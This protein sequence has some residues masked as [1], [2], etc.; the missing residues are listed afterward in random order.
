[1][2]AKALGDKRKEIIISSKVWVDHMQKKDIIE[3][4]DRSL[5][6]L[7]T[8]YLDMYLLHWPVAEVPIEERIEALRELKAAGKIRHYGISNFGPENLEEIL[9]V[10]D[11]CTNQI[12]Y[13]LF[14]RAVEYAV[15]P[16]CIEHTIPVMCYSSLMQGLLAGKYKSLAD[17]PANR[18]RTAMFDSKTHSQSRHGGPGAEQEGQAAL[19]TIWELTNTSGYSM[20]E[21]A[22]GWLKAQKGVE[23]VIVGTRNREQSKGLKKLLEVNLNPSLVTELSKATNTLKE[24]LG[25]NIDM[26]DHR[27]K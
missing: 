23:G 9:Q 5:K 20:E 13:N 14:H 18:A 21:L 17:F 15:L 1:L 22:V 2:L 4:C 12:G 6:N 19:D 16:T 24:A 26:W 11:V 3:A 8:D 27:S 10:T 7:Q 25:T